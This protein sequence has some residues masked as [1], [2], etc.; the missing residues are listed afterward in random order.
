MRKAISVIVFLAVLIVAGFTQGAP[1][2]K[3]AQ[4]QQTA[5]I[6]KSI[7]VTSPAG[8]QYAK[9][10]SCPITWTSQGLMGS[11]VNILLMQGTNTVKLLTNSPV[12]AGTFAWTISND[13]PAGGNYSIV[14]Q[15]VQ[16]PSVKGQSNAFSIGVAT[17]SSAED[18]GPVSVFVP[19]QVKI[20]KPM[21]GG[22]WAAGDPQDITWEF[23]G[24]PPG[25]ASVLLMKGSQVVKT[26]S[27]GQS[28]GQSGKG[29]IMPYYMPSDV[30]QGDGY[31]IKVVSTTNAKYR[32]TGG[33]FTIQPYLSLIV[34]QPPNNAPTANWG[35][36]SVHSITW[37]YT[38]SCGSHVQV[39][40]HGGVNDQWKI[41]PLVT[42]WSIGS[43]GSG[44]FSWT[45]PSEGTNGIHWIPGN[46]YQLTVTG[47]ENQKCW[48]WTG[49][50]TVS[51]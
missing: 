1:L 14:V 38:S 23:S 41:Y 44:N 45:V 47:V 39:K 18:K 50:F 22:N 19:E 27:T 2:N 40:L 9:L 15:S 13:I 51:Q 17:I 10:Q 32:G 24:N 37:T 35:V 25:Q 26:I 49:K 28:W 5:P 48:D 11:T 30:P 29:Y 43:N 7:K 4:Q 33:Q 36:G 34:T 31:F 8:G 16:T 12:G 42:S 3:S 46:V 6:L 20:T 21:Q